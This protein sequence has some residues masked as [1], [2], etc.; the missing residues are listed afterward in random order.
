MPV[1][2]DDGSRCQV[3]R[4]PLSVSLPAEKLDLIFRLMRVITD[5]YRVPHLFPKWAR[6]CARR[7]SLAST[8]FYRGAAMPHQFQSEGTVLVN[9]PPVDWWTVLFPEGANWNAIDDEPVFAMITHVFRERHTELP[10]L[11]FRVW[12]LTQGV[13]FGKTA[14]DWKRIA[15]M[16]RINAAQ[17]VNR[18]ILLTFRDSQEH[19]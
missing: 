18:E 1:E 3:C 17:A 2:D 16:D 6:G 10:G 12:A 9:N 19:L 15:Q 14:D 8:G 7:E 4:Y 5:Y 11:S 13:A